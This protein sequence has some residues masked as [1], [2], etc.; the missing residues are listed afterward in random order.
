MTAEEFLKLYK[1]AEYQILFNRQQMIKT[2]RRAWGIYSRS[3]FIYSADYEDRLWEENERL[4][5][6]LSDI[7]QAVS[8]LS[9]KRER[10]VLWLRYID[11]K[12]WSELAD[13]MCYSIQHIQRIHKKALEKLDIPL[14]YMAGENYEQTS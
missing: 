3:Y 1:K 13:E 14:K 12:N 4:A 7:E 10:K 8:R 9:D 5:G 11:G 2:E 6:V